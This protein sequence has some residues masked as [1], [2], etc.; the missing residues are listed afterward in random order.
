MSGEGT[1]TRQRVSPEEPGD[2]TEV[3][4]SSGT[5]PMQEITG[6]ASYGTGLPLQRQPDRSSERFALGNNLQ[7]DFGDPNVASLQRYMAQELDPEWDGNKYGNT[8]VLPRFGID[9]AWGCET[10]TSFNELLR[11]KGVQCNES[12]GSE[13][14]AGVPMCV[15][16]EATIEALKAEDANAQKEEK[17]DEETEDKLAFPIFDDQCFLVNRIRDILDKKPGPWG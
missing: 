10:Q 9:G 15:L 3:P 11:K 4:S 13:C 16:D 6:G 8:S 5:G 17:D 12:G 14:G 1:D 7:A 2:I